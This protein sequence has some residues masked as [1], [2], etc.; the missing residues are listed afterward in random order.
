MIRLLTL[1]SFSAHAATILNFTGTPNP[2]S[3]FGLTSQSAAG[4]YFQALT[5]INGPVRFEVMV[6]SATPQTI[7]AILTTQFYPYDPSFNV[8]SGTFQSVASATPDTVAVTPVVALTV[9]S[10]NVSPYYL[11]LYTAGGDAVWQGFSPF[12]ST[13]S[14]ATQYA[15][16]TVTSPQSIVPNN[17]PASIFY[18]VNGPAFGVRVVT[19][20][21]VDPPPSGDVP[22]PA[23]AWIALGGLIALAARRSWKPLSAIAIAPLLSAGIIYEPTGTLL[24]EPLLLDGTTAG[25]VKFQVTQPISGDI[26]F[27]VPI[28]YPSQNPNVFRIATAY[29]MTNVGPSATEADLIAAHTLTPQPLDNLDSGPLY[30]AAFSVPSLAQGTYYF[31]V[32]SPG[33]DVYWQTYAPN[34]TINT[35]A[36][37]APGGLGLAAAQYTALDTLAPYRS[38]FIESNYLAY[39][40]R[41]SDVPEPST[42]VL[43]AAFLLGMAAFRNRRMLALAFTLLPTLPAAV[44][45][46]QWDPASLFGIGVASDIAPLASFHVNQFSGSP[47]TIDAIFQRASSPPLLS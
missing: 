22:E 35:A 19:G 8:A 2:S 26:S 41:I 45:Y 21:A 27:D 29:L 1:I 32:Y 5:P 39:G 18:G 12:T 20:V 40:L 16:F 10:L 34:F 15:Q 28:V 31:V 47:I 25:Y 42:G 7:N 13:I 3:S 37:V 23:T 46:E 33:A 14:P 9:P 30:T 6:A 11:I 44:L 24:A 38:E 36:N 17:P 43:A 4:F